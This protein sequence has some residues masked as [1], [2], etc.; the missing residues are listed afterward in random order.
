MLFLTWW[1]IAF[2]GPTHE[3]TLIGHIYRGYNISFVGSLIG[4]G[5]GFADGLIGGALFAGLYNL[6]SAVYAISTSSATA[7]VDHR[8]AVSH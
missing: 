3:M 8:A 4:L 7:R 1:V 5:W 2:D 6:L